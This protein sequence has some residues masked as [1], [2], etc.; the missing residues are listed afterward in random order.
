MQK[1]RAVMGAAFVLKSFLLGADGRALSGLLK[2]ADDAFK[3]ELAC[4]ALASKCEQG[5]G[6]RCEAGR[7]FEALDALEEWI[8]RCHGLG[9]VHSGLIFIQSLSRAHAE[10]IFPRHES[11]APAHAFHVM[12]QVSNSFRSLVR[13]LYVSQ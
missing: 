8:W 11:S 13:S 3:R 6:F 5:K 1:G 12:R 9:C 7:G 10:R 4:L 2:L